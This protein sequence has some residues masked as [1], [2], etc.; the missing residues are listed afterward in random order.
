MS[1]SNNRLYNPNWTF[2]ELGIEP[3]ETLVFV[4][5]EAIKCKVLDD[6]AVEYKRERFDTLVKF[7][8]K[9][10]QYD[11]QWD[12]APRLFRHKGELLSEL[13]KK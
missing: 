11:G 5:N 13:R 3:G 10:C 8:R 1:K 6:R 4:K 9:H 12:S 2:S 7:A